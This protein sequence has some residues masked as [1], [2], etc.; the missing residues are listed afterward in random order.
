MFSIIL[1]LLI[2]YVYYKG[3]INF[4]IIDLQKTYYKDHNKIM[5]KKIDE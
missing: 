2:L 5:F 4:K 1:M 3:S